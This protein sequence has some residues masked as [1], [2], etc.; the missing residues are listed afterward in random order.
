MVTAGGGFAKRIESG[1]GSGTPDVFY[2]LAGHSGWIENKYRDRVPRPTT[3]CFPPSRDPD[4]DRSCKGLRKAQIAWWVEYTRAG[5]RGAILAGIGAMTYFVHPSHV[6]VFN[7]WTLI[8]FAC[9]ARIVVDGAPLREAL[10]S[11]TA[12]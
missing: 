1:L 7:T 9:K 2:C 12:I 6:R 10:C 3:V 5:G 8:D 4:D 11:Q